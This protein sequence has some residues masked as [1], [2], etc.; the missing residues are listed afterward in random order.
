M[1]RVIESRTIDLINQELDQ[2]KLTHDFLE[3]FSIATV[4]DGK[5]QNLETPEQKGFEGYLQLLANRILETKFAK[6]YMVGDAPPPNFRF[7]VMDH[8]VATHMIY[9]HPTTPVVIIT[10]PL[11]E[12]IRNIGSEDFLAA[13]V[14][15]NLT[16][17]FFGEKSGRR[18][19]AKLEAAFTDAAPTFLLHY[20]G[21]QYDAGEQLVSICDAVPHS[22][23]LNRMRNETH[24]NIAESFRERVV[25]D[26]YALLSQ[27]LKRR[28][29]SHNG[30][31]RRPETPL[32]EE[33]V[34]AALRFE[35]YYGDE[36][37][38]LGAD[39]YLEKYAKKIIEDPSAFILKLC[40]IVE[41]FDVPNEKQL[42]GYS[43][44]VPEHD[45]R[46]KLG[47]LIYGIANL[48]GPA[49][50]DVIPLYEAVQRKFGEAESIIRPFLR[51]RN[52]E[53]KSDKTNFFSASRDFG[54]SANAPTV[55]KFGTIR[56]SLD[57][58]YTLLES[59][60]SEDD[61]MIEACRS[62]S[63]TI[64]EMGDMSGALKLFSFPFF[65]GSFP[66]VY[67]D[68]PEND[69][70][71]RW[72]NRIEAINEGKEPQEG[73]TPPWDKI[74]GIA[75]REFAEKGTTYVTQA[76]MTIGVR[77][78]RL[79]KE[80]DAARHEPSQKYGVRFFKLGPPALVQDENGKMIG[81]YQFPDRY[82][83]Y[84]VPEMGKK[85]V[86]RED[87]IDDIAVKKIAA[88]KAAEIAMARTIE[89]ANKSVFREIET[90][91]SPDDVY[92]IVRQYP[93]SFLL[94][95]AIEGGEIEEKTGLPY[96]AR[97]V[98][99]LLGKLEPLLVKEPEVWGPVL[100]ILFFE[101]NYLNSNEYYIPLKENPIF[102]SE[103]QK[104]LHEATK[105]VQEAHKRLENL[106]K[107]KSQYQA[108]HRKR[109]NLDFLGILKR[110]TTE[111]D[112][113]AEDAELVR[114][115]TDIEKAYK[116]WQ[117]LYEESVRVTEKIEES[118]SSRFGR[119]FF[120]ADQAAQSLWESIYHNKS[121]GLWY[122]AFVYA[123]KSFDDIAA[124][125]VFNHQYYDSNKP[126]YRSAIANIP[127]M[128]ERARQEFE[129]HGTATFQDQMTMGRLDQIMIVQHDSLG[130]HPKHPVINFVLK[131]TQG[132]TEE[133]SLV[134]FDVPQALNYIDR[135]AVT[136][137]RDSAARKL[138][139]PEISMIDVYFR[140]NGFKGYAR[141]EEELGS[142]LHTLKHI[143]PSHAKNIIGGEDDE[144]KSYF[145]TSKN[146]KS[147]FMHAHAKH[148]AYQFLK[149]NPDIVLSNDTLRLVHELA[150]VEVS[151]TGYL[152]V[153]SNDFKA[154]IQDLLKHQVHLRADHDFK[155][156]DHDPDVLADTYVFMAR[157][158]VFNAYPDIMWGSNR[159]G[160]YNRL[161]LET[162]E[163]IT[164][165]PADF[166]K[167]RKYTERI[168][169]GTT[170]HD[171]VLRK[172]LIKSWAKS[173]RHE[174]GI[175]PM[176]A[177]A[178][179]KMEPQHESYL[180]G[181]LDV[182]NHLIANLGS[183]SSLLL[184]MTETM[185]EELETQKTATD[186]VMKNLYERAFKDISEAEILSLAGFHV[187]SLVKDENLRGETLDFLRGDLTD[188]SIEKYMDAIRLRQEQA[189]V[190]NTKYEN[191]PF[192]KDSNFDSIE[193]YYGITKT[194]L[195]LSQ[196]E[197]RKK[198]ASMLASAHENFWQSSLAVR[199]YY[200]NQLAFPD[201]DR[202]RNVRKNPLFADLMQRCIDSLLPYEYEFDPQHGHRI[203]ETDYN[204]YV[205]IA[206]DLIYSYMD[207][208]LISEKR[209][210]LSAALVSSKSIGESAEKSLDRIGQALATVLSN[211]GPAGAK[212]AQAVHSFP[213]LPDEMRRGM[214]NVKGEFDPP[215]RKQRI[216]R[217]SEVIPKSKSNDDT[218][219]TQKDIRHIGSGMGAGS[220]Q[221]TT[222]VQLKNPINGTDDI[223]FTH[224]RSHVGTHAK[225]E[226]EH[227]F[228]AVKRF[229]TR[230]QE[231]GKPIT[232]TAIKGIVSAM[233]QALSMVDTEVDYNTGKH[234][235]DLMEER[236]DGMVIEVSGRKVAFTTV[237]WLGHHTKTAIQGDEEDILAFKMAAIA[238]GMGF[239][240]W[241]DTKKEAGADADAIKVVAAAADTA[242]NIL[243]LHG[244]HSDD[245]RHG[246]NF[247]VYEVSET[248]SLGSVKLKA[249]DFIV[250]VYDLGAV[251]TEQPT[252]DQK[253]R[254][255]AA[256][257]KSF[258]GESDPQKA[259]IKGL[260]DA[261]TDDVSRIENLTI[262]PGGNYFA[263]T[264]RGMLA[265]NDFARELSPDDRIQAFLSAF[266]AGVTD[267]EI[268]RGAKMGATETGGG[269]AGMLVSSWGATA[270]KIFSGSRSGIDI[271]I[272]SLPESLRRGNQVKLGKISKPRGLS[273]SK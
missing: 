220:Y 233:S 49:I 244:S 169:F 137:S 256:V 92:R 117:S 269:M 34:D 237:G 52:G 45:F 157:S 263:A 114:F 166:Q 257:I 69:L 245:D 235:S 148:E 15:K 246:E 240:K 21:Y 221:V 74:I 147:S 215:T 81:S 22:D 177:F 252:A 125:P 118:F 64:S 54:E 200:I 211:L 14:A 136:R 253:A 18:N 47:M 206:R 185:M 46:N 96:G 151:F 59:D 120:D 194:K 255:G 241:V 223:A 95:P 17:F 150:T 183:S 55:G 127:A 37:T 112:T 75:Q 162:L 209:L 168:L 163:K 30:L 27:Y 131:H 82:P 242:E 110:K 175:D 173:V 8:F 190:Y 248:I 26:S 262:T 266:E 228:R 201:K 85:I 130:I 93:L 63:D 31:Q 77:D 224:L 99:A 68:D 146:W 176:Q 1:A 123:A 153:N 156:T 267:P 24:I 144:E 230:R 258:S 116:E 172:K 23:K 124:M 208:A 38:T 270:M 20:A 142:R 165:N 61:A 121:H 98:A 119:T 107:D 102:P 5:T 72:C 71:A 216:E 87:M 203:K 66:T 19:V 128:L 181:I 103:E 10:K 94:N 179:L 273:A 56:R 149:Q 264:L 62:M 97:A 108:K 78:P 268:L 16:T 154:E 227:F 4:L 161:V 3:F 198:L 25:E 11:L 180:E 160:G 73:F 76:L 2:G 140:L 152:G 202:I 28:R 193:F 12:R 111:T 226:F 174:Y 239:N 210:L 178:T 122:T 138:E 164:G 204:E 41:A 141:N 80:M 40:Q 167:V 115:D 251:N 199:T 247:H 129:E 231:K 145:R 205:D 213:D 259:L 7:V 57:T 134:L 155:I 90:I 219:V 234:Q 42:T 238:P 171:P 271:K 51:T 133:G 39:A 229:I 9:E 86:Y 84:L 222:R 104:M 143:V 272:H 250:S 36:L 53:N 106:R 113:P 184:E 35:F 91:T 232:E 70:F 88:F 217:M 126:G 261:I 32:E 212:M 188:E 214:G 236:Y 191:N 29:Q 187:D 225:N 6:D 182:G 195:N 60:E 48:G 43:R 254:M 67:G 44:E 101:K 50:E 265:R 158:S 135:I 139:T 83:T 189:E 33:P 243:K 58:I 105:R 100:E 249:G 13:L 196:P 170:I 65:K 192:K 89:E 218:P 260:N 207:E 197:D 132:M 159:K 109:T 186:A 79:R